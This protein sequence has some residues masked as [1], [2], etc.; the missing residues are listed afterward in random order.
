MK[1]LYMIRHAKSSW[2]YDVPDDQRPL[3]KRG[4]RDA[5]L[6]GEHLKTLIKPIDLVLSSPAKRAF[7]TA[8]IILSKLDISGDIFKV[9]RELYDFGGNQVIETIKNC[10]N[11]INTLMIFGH[12]HAF[13]SLVNLFG[14]ETIDNLPTAG[15]V[16][17]EFEEDSWK[18]I[19]VGKNL[20]KI[21]PK[22]LR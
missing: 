4:L 18:S 10:D 2:E 8:K 7:D 14:S 17:I 21:F 16:G 22:S 12:N 9:E 13:T 11:K 20:L 19:S 15:V 1:T 3:N 6:V 5:E